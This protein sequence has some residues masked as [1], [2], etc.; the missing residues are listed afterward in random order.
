MAGYRSLGS[1][2]TSDLSQHS[3]GSVS[4]SVHVLSPLMAHITIRRSDH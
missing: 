3:I 1:S 4:F 2:F